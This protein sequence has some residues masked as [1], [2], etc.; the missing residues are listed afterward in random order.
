MTNTE[1]LNQKEEFIHWM[2]SNNSQKAFSYQ[3]LRRTL[4]RF[5]DIKSKMVDNQQLE[6]VKASKSFTFNF[7]DS[8]QIIRTKA[9]YS[10]KNLIESINDNFY[11]KKLLTL[12]NSN[13]LNVKDTVIIKSIVN[14]I[15]VSTLDGKALP[16]TY[17]KTKGKRYY[18]DYVNIP[19]AD[20]RRIKINGGNTISVDITAS[21]IQLLSQCNITGY[22]N[23]L[24]FDVIREKDFWLFISK[25]LNKTRDEVK[26]LFMVGMFGKFVPIELFSLYPTFFSNISKM[27]KNL[28]YKSVHTLYLQ[29]ENEIMSNMMMELALNKIHFLPIHDCLI[30]EEK[31][32]S[33]VTELFSKN[34]VKYKIEY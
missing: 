1:R 27:K 3:T 22:D 19:K 18:S 31:N 13:R 9:I 34:N 16:L 8:K 2:I 12:T 26:E 4:G 17:I 24:F 25:K 10:T 6:L 7:R 21:S 33:M 5:E 28:G 29:I 23:Q 32:Y 20:R 14:T 15:T 30:V 11:Y